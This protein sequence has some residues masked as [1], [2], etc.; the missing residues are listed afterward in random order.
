MRISEIAEKTCLTRQW[1]NKLADRG[2]IPGVKRKVN[3]RLRIEDGS[4][5]REWIR[6]TARSVS[7]GRSKRGRIHERT[8]TAVSKELNRIR[9][10]TTRHIDLSKSL[11]KVRAL[12]NEESFLKRAITRD[13]YTT[14]EIANETGYHRRHI[15]RL[16]PK[17]PG[18]I[19]SGNQWIFLKSEELHLWIRTAIGKRS[20]AIRSARADHSRSTRI[21]GTK[22][23][24]GDLI[25]LV[26]RMREVTETRPIESWTLD[27]INAFLDDSEP[28]AK[29]IDAANRRW[30][31]LNPSR[32][33]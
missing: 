29:A 17:V 2:E 8:L 32:S 25:K 6:L 27:E 20:A 21:K 9:T 16:A 31:D 7:R 18:A 33:S 19:Y 13:H 14:R 3:G 11:E 22:T 5:L 15:A 4:K 24:T 1:L 23:I 12:Q 30:D 28:L 26:S 10:V